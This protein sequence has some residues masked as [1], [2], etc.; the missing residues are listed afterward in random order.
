MGMVWRRPN[1]A[2]RDGPGTKECASLVLNPNRGKAVHG[3][4]LQPVGSGRPMLDTMFQKCPGGSPFGSTR[5]M[6][7]DWLE[8]AYGG[9]HHEVCESV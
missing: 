5:V 6:T 2:G 9:I 1:W 4:D 3:I 7:D 8:R